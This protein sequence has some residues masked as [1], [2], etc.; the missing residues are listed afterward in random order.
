MRTLKLTLYFLLAAALLIP[1]LI[2]AADQTEG[3]RLGRPCAGCHATNGYAP[4]EYVARIAGQNT[5]YL[6]KVMTE[7]AT[8]KRP[9][10]VE[11]TI[12]SKGYDD[13]GLKAISEY[14]GAKQW[15]NTTNTINQKA[16][17]AGKKLAK[18]N[19]CLDCHG[20]NGYGSAETPRI[21]GQ[22]KMYLYEALIR[23][24]TGKINSEEM[25]GVKDLTDKQ[26]RELSEYLASMK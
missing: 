22:N 12:V 5:E 14:Y 7:F 8:G 25:A 6:T 13:A 11:M 18:A 10:S 23:Y 19:S 2:F 24:K 1:S 15:Q 16:A 21:A 9:A 17:A 3:Q 4:G 20:T 26:L